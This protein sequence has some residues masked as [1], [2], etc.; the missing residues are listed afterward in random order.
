MN[1]I[2]S[3]NTS[4]VKLLLLVGLA[5]FVMLPT[6]IYPPGRD[7]GMFA[8]AGHL[9]LKG[10]VPFRDFWD[11]KPPAIYYIYALSE[12]LFSYSIHAIRWL[13]LFWQVATAAVLFQIT[14][15]I[16]KS[17]D[18]AVI[19]GLIYVSAYA[20]RGWWNTAQPDD[21]L[22]L[23]LAVA[24][25]LLLRSLDRER[26][27]FLSFAEGILVGAAFY[28]K[29][30]MGLMLAVCM[31]VLLVGKGRSRRTFGGLAC[32]VGGFVLCVGSYAVYLYLTG[33]W[34]EFLYT[35]FTW[36]REY[37]RVGAPPHTVSGL[38]HLGDI[39][40]SHFS[41]VSLAILALISYAWAATTRSPGLRINL[42]ALWALAAL[43]NLYIQNKFYIYHF[44][45]LAA[46]LSIGA[47]SAL[48]FPFRKHHAQPLRRVAVLVLVLVVAIPLL[49]VNSRYNVYC[50]QVYRDSA[51]A[52]ADR[53]LKRRDLN[54]Y[55]MNVRFTSDD[56]SL[57]A[58]LVVADYIKHTTRPDETVF[59][60]GCETLVYYCAGRPHVSR[61]IHNFP[62]RCNWSPDR[63]GD[64]LLA[65]LVRGRP[66][67]ILIVRNDPAWWATGTRDDSL[68]S[69]GRYPGIEKFIAGNYIFDR[70]IEDFLIFRRRD[71][72]H[73]VAT[74]GDAVETKKGM[75]KPLPAP[76][77]WG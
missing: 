64:E 15:R 70:G 20:S 55:Y 75:N 28:L 57:P 54:D 26:I 63:Y 27:L 52:L 7:Q 31:V 35:E 62:L 14:R 60:W 9:V 4:P 67:L 43:M 1:I 25:L 58:D 32:M 22:N 66:K 6:L 51:R 19:A 53:L 34:R 56:F 16:A 50:M 77:L 72:G 44:A 8:Y 61:F 46:P 37:G 68:R 17:D 49:T 21:F 71:V 36:A 65:S 33:A 10:A 38:L 69:L 41:F 74:H 76:L 48:A 30:P 40:S 12:F 11:T 3:K 23:P 42:I 59:I 5:L 29:Y 39:F 47:S 24:V 2:F 73:D 45:P 18:V 13:D